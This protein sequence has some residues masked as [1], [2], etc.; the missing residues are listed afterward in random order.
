M[1]EYSNLTIIIPTLNEAK[2]I[3]ILISKLLQ[4]YKGVHIIVSDDGS[5]DGTGDEVLYFKNRADV[6]LLDRSAEK[7][8]GLTASVL[9]AVLRV[10]TRDIIVMDADLQHPPEKVAALA[11]ALENCNLAIGVRKEVKDWGIY[12]KVV[13]KSVS[14]FCNTVF[15]LRGKKTSKDIMSGF[16]GIRTKFFQGIIKEHGSSYIGTGYK[17]LLETLKFV[18]RDEK[19]AEVPYTGF[20]DRMYGKSKAGTKQ[21]MD[22]IR[23]TLK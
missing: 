6:Q 2:N 7:V 16:F 8:H 12:R 3:K 20:H 9:D 15:A 13:S 10:K 11:E 21:L 4:S 22:I 5:K 1:Y 23:A 19:V 14:T 18:N 17:V